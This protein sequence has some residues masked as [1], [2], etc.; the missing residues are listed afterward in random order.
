MTK[1]LVLQ[2]DYYEDKIKQK[3]M[4][5]VSGLAG[6]ES[7]AIDSKDKKLTVVG[8]IDAVKLVHRLRKLCRADIISVG[9][10]KEPEK[11]KDDGKKDDGKKDDGKKGGDGD[12]KKSG[13]GDDKKSG[14]GGGGKG[15]DEK[16]SG[17]DGNKKSNNESKGDAVKVFPALPPP[18]GY[19]QYYHP[20]YPQY[21][22]PAVYHQQ[23]YQHYP[24]Q[25]AYYN[26]SSEED[27]NSCVIC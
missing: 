2:L 6:I 3:A 20:Q 16:K 25:S 17:G 9:P 27:P 21:L 8:D 12:K 4:Q 7:I 18:P 19:P 5:K 11:K 15:S 23:A 22:P 26:R 1:K 24:A 10:A 14:E 13:G